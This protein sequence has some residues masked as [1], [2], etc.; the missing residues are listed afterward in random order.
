MSFAE[1]KRSIITSLLLILF[2]SFQ[3]GRM[4][5]YHS[6]IFGNIVISHSHPFNNPDRQHS[7]TELEAIS[8]IN[9]CALED[10]IEIVAEI[11]APTLVCEIMTVGCPSD[12]ASGNRFSLSGRAPPYLNII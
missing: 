7:S 2:L 12:V 6:H 9:A 1:N 8:V 5:C 4:L 10:N 3:G 11:A